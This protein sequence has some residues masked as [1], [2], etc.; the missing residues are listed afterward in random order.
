MPGTREI[1]FSRTLREKNHLYPCA[2]LFQDQIFFNPGLVV[3]AF[4]LSALEAEA[5]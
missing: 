2:F 4:N 5:C 3:H 1:T